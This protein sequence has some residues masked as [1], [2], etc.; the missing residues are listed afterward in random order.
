MELLR[1]FVAR[2]H[3]VLA[4]SSSLYKVAD[5]VENFVD[6]GSRE[7]QSDQETKISLRTKYNIQVELNEDATQVLSISLRPTS[8]QDDSTDIS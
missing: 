1:A 8:E 7:I 6:N 2:G 4:V 5:G 3:V